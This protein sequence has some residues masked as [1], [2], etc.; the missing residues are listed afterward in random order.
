[1]RMVVQGHFQPSTPLNRPGLS[2]ETA[3]CGN[4]AVGH[5]WAGKGRSGGWITGI[6]RGKVGM[7]GAMGAILGGE[8]RV[9]DM[10][11]VGARVKLTQR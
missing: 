4:Q 10:W 2:A 6:V 8:N 11:P 3:I 1:M 5:L 7:A 9:F